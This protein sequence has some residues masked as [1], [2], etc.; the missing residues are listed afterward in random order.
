MNGKHTGLII[1]TLGFLSLGTFSWWS[2]ETERQRAISLYQSN[3]EL[4][5]EAAGRS[6]LAQLDAQIIAIRTGASYDPQ[7]FVSTVIDRSGRIVTPEMRGI[8][9][10]DDFLLQV[11]SA[12]RSFLQGVLSAI[13]VA[14]VDDAIAKIAQAPK[15]LSNPTQALLQYHLANLLDKDGRSIEAKK[16]RIPLLSHDSL[17]FLPQGVIADLLIRCAPEMDSQEGQRRLVKVAISTL[18]PV[19]SEPRDPAYLWLQEIASLLKPISPD[20][21]KDIQNSINDKLDSL[22]LRS[23]LMGEDFAKT[24]IVAGALG[25]SQGRLHFVWWAEEN[26]EKERIEFHGLQSRHRHALGK[27]IEADEVNKFCLLR[28]PQNKDQQTFSLGSAGGGLLLAFTHEATPRVFPWR[29]ALVATFVLFGLGI[30]RFGWVREQKSLAEHR[31]ALTA[32]SGFLANVSH[33]LKTPVA[34]LRLFAET[35]AGDHVD[36]ERERRRMLD[37][38]IRESTRLGHFLHHIMG[39]AR[40]DKTEFVSVTIDLKQVL[41]AR[42][43]QWQETASLRGLRLRL[44][45]RGELPFIRGD[46]TS[47][48]DGLDNVVENAL[49]FSPEAGCVEILAQ[50]K[51]DQVEIAVSDQGPGIPKDDQVRVFDRFYRGEHALARQGTGTG[52]GLHIAKIATERAQGTLKILKTGNGGTTMLFRIPAETGDNNA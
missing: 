49:A 16:T 5:L 51:D 13:Y 8:L 12:E 4:E 48:A 33:Q 24:D 2:F 11:S 15:N 40:L 36:D 27:L 37:I 32:K 50:V 25:S 23:L 17:T 9:L 20:L 34:N 10:V 7:S 28:S 47:L 19:L 42:L 38:L 1:F 22:R 45:I 18:L 41:L 3:R 35:L 46:A 6:L 31:R 14:R 39:E 43:E 44:S 52:L 29:S 21:R 30:L 26:K